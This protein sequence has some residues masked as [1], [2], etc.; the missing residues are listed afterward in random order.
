MATVL[1]FYE[2]AVD[3][4]SDGLVDLP[5]YPYFEIAHY[6]VSVLAL[7]EEPGARVLSRTSPL[8][9]WF[10]SMLNCF[11]GALLTAILLAQPPIQLFINSD[12]ILLA[13]VIWYLIFY[14]PLDGVYRF[15][16]MLPI[17]VVLS[18]MKEV[19]RSK[20]ILS[21]ITLAKS[22]YQDNL[23]IMI[24]IAWAKGAGGGLLSSFDQFVR[25]IWIP[26][27]NELI[28][29]SYATRITLI[30]AVLFSLK[31]IEYLPVE[32]NHLMLYYTIFTGIN[33][34]WMM[35]TRSAFTFSSV[36]CFLFKLFFTGDFSCCT[37]ARKF[38]IFK[39]DNDTSKGGRVNSPGVCRNKC[40]S[41]ARG[42]RGNRRARE[43][44]GSRN[45][46]HK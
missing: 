1:N 2:A 46:K 9:C 44:A 33:K 11:G 3:E 6:I 15:T 17:K 4:L 16:A 8:T 42:G 23:P 25:G 45:K 26:E 37:L 22:K 19:T 43:E 41:P 30:G 39:T 38:G 18:V 14:S 10:S 28:R 7:R 32:K 13:S 20:K 12:D 27:K 35:T 31:E 5:L 29:M 21:G 40:P 34:C 24:S 36:E